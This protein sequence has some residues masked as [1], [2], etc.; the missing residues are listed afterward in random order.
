M[1]GLEVTCDPVLFHC[2]TNE[3]YAKILYLIIY[4]PGQIYETSKPM[5]ICQDRLWYDKTTPLLLWLTKPTLISHMISAI[6]NWL[7]A[8][9]YFVFTQGPRLNKLSHWVSMFAEAGRST[10]SKLFLGSI[11]SSK[12]KQFACPHPYFIY[13]STAS[14]RSTELQFCL[15]G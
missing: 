1:K 3:T 6:M 9:L 8:L 14:F 4:L 2:I 10:H 13:Q 12:S 15:E 7:G 11:F 5:C